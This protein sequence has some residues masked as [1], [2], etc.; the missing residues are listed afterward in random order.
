[1]S[2]DEGEIKVKSLKKAIDVLNCFIEVLVLI[3]INC[4]LLSYSDL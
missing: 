4:R 3:G 2:A 1:M